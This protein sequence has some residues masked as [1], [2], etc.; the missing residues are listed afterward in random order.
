MDL[1]PAPRLDVLEK[2]KAQEGKGAP[3]VA[4]G[5]NM[6]ASKGVTVGLEETTVPAQ[7]MAGEQGF[8]MAD[9]TGPSQGLGGPN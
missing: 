7:G 9:G 8:R 4:I 2:S 3:G 6:E 1:K 5:D